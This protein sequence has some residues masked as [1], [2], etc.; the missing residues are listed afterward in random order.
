MTKYT[1]YR[2]SGAETRSREEREKIHP[3]WR[4]IGWILMFIFPVMGW[5]GSIYLLD[6]NAKQ[7][8]IA[9]PAS[10]LA[11]G[12]DQYLFVKIGLTIVIVFILF[13]IFQLI[14]FAILR[15]F[16]QERYGPMDIPRAAYRGK[17]SKR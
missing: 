14:S 16:G 7:K 10:F 2:P 11:K 8:W 15:G 9:I 3:I 12:A 5:F 4:G 17:K 1:S 6:Q 13:F